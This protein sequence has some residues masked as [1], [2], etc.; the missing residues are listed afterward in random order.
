VGDD[1]EVALHELPDAHAT[2][3][4]NA[5]ADADA[6]VADADAAADADADADAGER[7]SPRAATGVLEGASFAPRSPLPLHD[8]SLITPLSLPYRAA[9]AHRLRA[10]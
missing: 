7:A 4:A 8:L 1:I 5:A 9:R 6:A 10:A 2:A 3:D